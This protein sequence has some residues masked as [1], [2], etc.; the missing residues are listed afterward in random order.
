MSYSFNFRVATKA[1]ARERAKVE[2]A[3]VVASQ[4]VH[5]QDSE[6]ALATLDAFLGLLVDDDT[7]DI[8]VAVNGSVSWDYVS[9]ADQAAVPLTSASVGV[10]AYL[11]TKELPE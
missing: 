11:T 6:A 9:D 7:R 1:D 10:S 8:V 4:P 2:L 3:A 5:A